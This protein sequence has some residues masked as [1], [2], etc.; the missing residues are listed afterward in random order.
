MPE[1]LKTKKSCRE[2][3][4]CENS[5]ISDENLFKEYEVS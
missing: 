4:F 2:E 3:E 5:T 1:S